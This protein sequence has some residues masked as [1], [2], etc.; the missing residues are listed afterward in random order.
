MP[1]FGKNRKNISL[2]FWIY[3]GIKYYHL[4]IKSDFANDDLDFEAINWWIDP[5]IGYTIP[6]KFSKW[7]FI[8]QND[9]GGFGLG[10]DFSWWL[11]FQARYDITKHLRINLGWIIQDIKYTEETERDRFT[12]DVQLNGSMAGI[13]IIF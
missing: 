11:E 13:A 6:F 1:L 3:A 10:S 8:F 2:G 4:N 7:S 9:Y 12:Y 5:I